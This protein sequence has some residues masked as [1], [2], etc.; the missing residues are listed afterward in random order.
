MAMGGFDVRIAADLS[1]IRLSCYAKT[2]ILRGAPMERRSN[3]SIPTV[4][5]KPDAPASRRLF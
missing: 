1:V 4:S 5:M 3:F 2:T